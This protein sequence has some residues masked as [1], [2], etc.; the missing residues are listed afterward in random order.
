MKDS[1]PM[2]HFLLT[3]VSILAISSLSYSQ[4]LDPVEWKFELEKTGDDTYD[5]IY[6]AEIE[7]GWTV[8]SQFTSDEGPVPTYIEYENKDGIEL[9]GEA[10]ESGKRKEGYDKIFGVDVIKFL[11]DEPFIIKQKIKVTDA[12]QPLSGYLTFMTCDNEKCLPPK[13]VEFS[14]DLG[15]GSNDQ[16]GSVE[17][18]KTESGGGI[19]SISLPGEDDGS[20][21]F[22]PVVW[23][24]TTKKIEEGVFDLIYQADIEEGWATYS[25]DSNIEGP[26]P[27]TVYYE[28][29]AGIELMGDPVESGK[30]KEGKEP[31]FNNVNVIK[32]LPDEPYI[33]TQRVRVTDPSLPIKGYIESMACD[34]SKCIKNPDEYF[35]F[36]LSG[37]GQ[38]VDYN[39]AGMEGIDGAIDLPEGVIDQTRPSLVKTYLSPLSDCGSEESKRRKDFGG[40]S[41]QGYWEALQP[42]LPLVF[43]Q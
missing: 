25:K 20:K 32:F 7:K 38:V 39:S 5:L 24:I 3:I 37:A 17:E 26:I 12:S 6:T 27:T 10:S 2:K 33:I 29:Q 13:D 19:G 28:E 31:A 4:I 40:Y 15:G 22:T 18:S 35:A 9:V 30:K 21:I 42:Y 43:F 8:Y 16:G 14:F 34:K 11:S 36:D 1:I 41:L 23:T